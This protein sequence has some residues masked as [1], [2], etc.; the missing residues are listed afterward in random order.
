MISENSDVKI[1]LGTIFNTKS[2]GGASVVNNCI[3]K[4]LF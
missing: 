4:K 3:K 2:T 1:I